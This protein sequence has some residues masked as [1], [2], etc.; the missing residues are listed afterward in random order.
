MYSEIKEKAGAL[1]AFLCYSV[2]ADIIRPFFYK[3]KFFS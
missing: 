3:S 2:G 1:P